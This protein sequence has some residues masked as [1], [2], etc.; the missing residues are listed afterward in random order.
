[1]GIKWHP[2]I[3]FEHCKC[4]QFSG[5]VNIVN[6]LRM[7]TM[8]SAHALYGRT[9]QA[10]LISYRNDEYGICVGLDELSAFEIE[11]LL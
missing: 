11:T 2:A 10:K 1:M 7:S 5:H 6:K 9:E 4:R 3:P 8:A